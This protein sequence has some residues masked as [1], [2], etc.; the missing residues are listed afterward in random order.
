MTSPATSGATRRTDARTG[1]YFAALNTIISGFAIYINGQGVK[2]FSDSTLYTALKNA[3]VGVA[4]LIPFLFMTSNRAELK[5]LNRRQWG[6]LALLA[7]IGGSVPYAL[8]FRGLQ[9]TTSVTSSL[10]NHAQF[11]IV[12][13]LAILFLGE[14]LG[15]LIWLAML[16]LLVGTTLGSNLHTLAWNQGTLLVVLSTV[17]FA[18][19]VVL[20]KRLLSD[21][22]MLTVMA[23]KMSAGSALLLVYVGA[24]GHLGA[25]TSLTATQWEYALVTG[26]ILLAFTFTAFMALRHVTATAATAI[27]AAAPLITTLLTV[28]AAPHIELAPVNGLGLG[29]IALATVGVFI[30]GMRREGNYPRGATA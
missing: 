28:I 24:T 3:V 1:Y 7:V 27:P 30:L 29:I 8:F 16:A 23:A 21:I 2:V 9:L 15:I 6:L 20:A 11:L 26:L 14:R 17:L 10:L 5:R 4:L 25:V 13:V 18:A 19:G 12:A 22:S